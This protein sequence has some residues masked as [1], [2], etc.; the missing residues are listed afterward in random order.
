MIQ[1]IVTSVTNILKDSTAADTVDSV[2]RR[3]LSFGYDVSD[4]DA[5]MIAFTMQK[6]TSQ[7]LNETNQSFIPD[8]L[9]ELF[10]DR[11]CGEFLMVKRDTG[12]LNL[13]EMDIGNAIQSVKEGDTTVTFST[14]GSDETKLNELLS[15][16]MHGKEGDLLCYRR[17]RW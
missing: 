4:V 14:E 5:W 10:V 15:W 1:T 3:L 13:S 7:I 16:L 9:M 8:G 12:S 17:M 11:V 6:V 2:I